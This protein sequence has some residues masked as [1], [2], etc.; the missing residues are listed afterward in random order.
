[1]VG[2]CI[3]WKKISCRCPK[4]PKHLKL[5]GWFLYFLKK[6]SSRFQKKS[7]IRIE[8]FWIILIHHQALFHCKAYATCSLFFWKIWYILVFWQYFWCQ[9]QR[10]N[11]KQKQNNNFYVK[12]WKNNVFKSFVLP[13]ASFFNAAVFHRLWSAACW[14]KFIS[15]FC[16]KKKNDD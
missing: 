7:Q 15:H 9:F 1:M 16:W 11:L 4:N 13:R 8:S 14:S 2:F 3:F 6:I 12:S 10:V 5:I